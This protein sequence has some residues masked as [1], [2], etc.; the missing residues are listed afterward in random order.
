MR[1]GIRL[2]EGC[3]KTLGTPGKPDTPFRF[4]GRH[5]VMDDGNGLHYMRARYY[6]PVGWAWGFYAHAVQKRPV[7]SVLDGVCWQCAIEG[8]NDV[9]RNAWAQTTCPP[10]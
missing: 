5:G 2:S 7:F 10:T 4:V 6:S 1:G 3:I 9:L 8:E